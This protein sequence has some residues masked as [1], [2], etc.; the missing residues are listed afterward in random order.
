MAQCYQTIVHDA[1]ITEISSLSTLLF[2]VLVKGLK[3]VINPRSWTPRWK[4]ASL[5]PSNHTIL[6]LLTV[7]PV[8]CAS[9][10]RSN[11]SLCYVKN[12]YRSTMGEDRLNALLLLYIHK[13]ITLDYAA[14]I[15]IYARKNPRKITFINPLK[16]LSTRGIGYSCGRHFRTSSQFLSKTDNEKSGLFTSIY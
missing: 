15:N 4:L 10:E 8:T 5:D 11:S 16:W 6:R 13:D 14:V 3:A 12:V 2:V 7:T 9:V 1:L